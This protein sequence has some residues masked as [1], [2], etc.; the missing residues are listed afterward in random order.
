MSS[1]LFRKSWWVFAFLA[2]SSIWYFH[3]MRQKDQEQ[4]ELQARLEALEA[5]KGLALEEKEE[6]QL[7]IDSQGDPAWIEMTLMKNLGVAPEGQKKV[8][9]Q[10]D[11]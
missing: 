3:G 5:E 1:K 4:K 9:F 11:E 7:Q 8:Y 2:L 10:K 6:L